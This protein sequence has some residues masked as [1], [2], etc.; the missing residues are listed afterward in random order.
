MKARLIF[1]AVAMSTLCVD[2]IMDSR[3]TQIVGD[4]PLVLIPGSPRL[5][6]QSALEYTP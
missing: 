5:H 1:M 2:Q 3:A 6:S 4:E